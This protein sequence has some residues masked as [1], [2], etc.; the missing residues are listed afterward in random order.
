MKIFNTMSREKEEFKPMDDEVGF[1]SCGP[2]VYWHPHI[3]NMRSYI[4]NDTL[5]RVLEYNN[6]K[7]KHVM[8]Y[9]D[10]GHL[11]SD[12]DEGEDKIEKAAAKEKKTAQEIAEFYIKAF[13]TDALK[14][15]IIPPTVTCKATEY[16]KEQ[17]DIIKDL[18]E[19][20]FTYKTDDGIYFDTTKFDDYAK[21]GRLNIDGL[22]TGHRTDM[23]GKKHKTDFA[24]WKFSETPG[25]RQQEWESPWGI[26]FPG[27]HTECVVMA[28]A[29]LGEQFDIHTG[30]E[31]HI[32]V[33]HTNEIAQAECSYQKRPWVK[34]WMHGSYLN[35]DGEKI[36]KSK[37]GLFTI[38]ELAEKGFDPLAFRYFCLTSLY[39]KQTNFSLEA[40]ESSQKT[41]EKLRNAVIELRKKDDSKGSI[42]KHKKDFLEAINDD[43]NTPQALSVLWAVIRDPE[44]GSKEKLEL[45]YDFDRVLGLDLENYKEKAVEA[46]EDVQKLL[47]EREKARKEKDWKKADELRD[48]IKELGFSIKDTP[49]GP[50][51][52]QE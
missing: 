14:L 8:N 9:T 48:K 22:D 34:Y 10:V 13:D 5:K 2:T 32:Q 46:T 36:S 16:I 18:E 15:N 19:K 11:T 3:G 45:T 40:L 24:L 6:F 31:D 12:A 41:L 43:L 17:I 47:E 1:Y 23:R 38:P 50:V 26:G 37:G 21:L 49:E 20:G 44:L 25:V 33:H 35:F 27:W 42:D 52:A 30:G 4:F 29:H 7:V 28:S 39:R 51:L